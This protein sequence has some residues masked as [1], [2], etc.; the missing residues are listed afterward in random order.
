MSQSASNNER[1]HILVVED[2]DLLRNMF[3][4]AFQAKHTVDATARIEEG[5]KLYNTKRAQVIFLDVNLPDGNGHDL[6]RRIKKRDPE[7]FIVMATSSRYRED[8]EEAVNNHVDG[9]I[10]KPFDMKQINDYVDGYLQRQRRQ[11]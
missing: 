11:A 2:D 5:W 3:L 1:L 8:K 9:F 4:Y 10:T 6:A 7:A